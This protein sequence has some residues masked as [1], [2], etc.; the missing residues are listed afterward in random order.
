MKLFIFEPYKWNHCGGA[1][2]VIAR[3]FQ[4]AV[5]A[6]IAT[7]KFEVWR[8]MRLGSGLA[9][10][11]YRRHQF[12]TDPSYFEKPRYHQWLLTHEVIVNGHDRIQVLF[13][14]WNYA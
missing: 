14:N 3:T 10:R 5:N 1:I 8:D 2:G 4:E 6:V 7:D 12:A 11:S 13:D 9:M